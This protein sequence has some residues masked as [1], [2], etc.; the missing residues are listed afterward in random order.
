MPSVAERTASDI[1]GELHATRL[2]AATGMHLC[3]NHPNRTTDRFGRRNRL[4]WAS[5]HASRRNR[6]TVASK[7]VLRLILVQIHRHRRPRKEARILPKI[8]VRSQL[9]DW[10][11]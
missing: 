7:E 3:L 1:A 8:T 11:H 6:D 9:E 2:A 10:L 4:R 5:R